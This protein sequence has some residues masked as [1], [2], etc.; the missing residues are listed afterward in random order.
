MNDLNNHINAYLE[1]CKCRKHLDT[2]TLKAYSIDLEQYLHFCTTYHSLDYFSRQTLDQ[3]ITSL[4]KQY[5]P[6]TIKR[7]IASIKAFFHY[8]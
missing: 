6:K 4:H 1:Y 2:K 3:F 5:K 8:F 7:K